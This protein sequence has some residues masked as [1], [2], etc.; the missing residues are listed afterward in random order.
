MVK[1][2]STVKRVKHKVPVSLSKRVSK[3]NSDRA[4]LIREALSIEKEAN[5]RGLSV[6]LTKR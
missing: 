4:K 3:W 2:K 5:K 6:K 1:K